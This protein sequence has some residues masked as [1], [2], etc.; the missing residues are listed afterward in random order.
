MSKVNSK[1]YWADDES[2]A[3]CSINDCDSTDDIQ[4][5]YCGSFC[6]A[7]LAEHCEHCEICR[8][9]VEDTDQ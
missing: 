5:S 2:E 6:A 7:H 3:A 8:E 9:E 1:V 4:S